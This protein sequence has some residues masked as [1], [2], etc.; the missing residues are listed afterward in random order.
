MYS[1][2]SGEKVGVYW[3]RTSILRRPMTQWGE[4][5]CTLFAL[6][7]FGLIKMCFNET[8]SKV[9]IGKYVANAIPI[10]NFLKKRDALSPLLFNFS[11][12]YAIRWVQ[13]KQEGMELNGTHQL[14]VYHKEKHRSSVS[15]IVRMVEVDT[16]KIK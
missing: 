4:S 11:L 15:L 9:L 5:Y 6:R 10:H 1:F 7:L 3:D 8:Y 16:E 12:E 13:E 2:E 14:L